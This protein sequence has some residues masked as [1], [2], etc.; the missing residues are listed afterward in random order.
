MKRVERRSTADN[1]SVTQAVLLRRIAQKSPPPRNSPPALAQSHPVPEAS[2]PPHPFQRELSQQRLNQTLDVQVPSQRQ[3]PPNG[4]MAPA[5]QLRHVMATQPISQ[6]QHHQQQQQHKVDH[7]VSASRSPS[8]GEQDRYRQSTNTVTG[9][10]PVSYLRDEPSHDRHRNRDRDHRGERVH[11]RP[12]PTFSPSRSPSLPPASGRIS[13]QIATIK[14]S[15]SPDV[16]SHSHSSSRGRHAAEVDRTSAD[17]AQRLEMDIDTTVSP[18]ASMSSATVT[19]G[20]SSAGDAVPGKIINEVTK[21]SG[22]GKRAGSEQEPE[23]RSDPDGEGDSEVELDAGEDELEE[24][25]SNAAQPPPSSSSLSPICNFHL[26]RP[27]ICLSTC[28]ST[29]V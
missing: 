12:T 15:Q 26:T 11:R 6:H 28:I 23:G 25:G 4:S 10:A 8:G 27:S 3:S 7:P 13:P 29:S 22:A 24:D 14:R 2:N 1:N 18:S 20:T 9:S 16:R 17:A 19:G 5:D 21:S